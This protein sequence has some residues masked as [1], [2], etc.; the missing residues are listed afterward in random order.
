MNKEIKEAPKNNKTENKPQPS[1]IPMDL[2]LESLEPAYREGLLKYARES[3]REGFY[4]STMYDAAIRHLTDFFFKGEDFDSD[5]EKLGIKKM[6]LGGALFSILCMVDTVL[7]HPE[8]DD[9]RKQKEKVLFD[10]NKTISECIPARNESTREEQI[11]KILLAKKTEDRPNYEA[12]KNYLELIE[13][14]KEEW[15]NL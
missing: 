7:N 9:R 5:A 1:L 10:F 6:H 2:L 15:N 14:N 4:T 3:W 12:V 8:K 13:E 11:E